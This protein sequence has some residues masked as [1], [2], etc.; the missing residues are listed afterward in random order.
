MNLY[1]KKYADGLEKSFQG[2]FSVNQK[3]TF[4][5]NISRRC[6]A[7]YVCLHLFGE[8][9][10]NRFNKIIELD[11]KFIN[12][13]YDVY[14]CEID[15]SE[16]GVG[17]FYYKYEI[18]SDCSRFYGVDSSYSALKEISPY[19][20]GSIQ[21]L[22]YEESENEPDWIYGGIMYHIF[23]DRFCKSGKCVP[24]KE[25]IMNDDWYDG[26]PQYANV[27]GGYVENNM[28]FGG[29][30]YGIINKLDYISSLGVNCLYLSPIFEAHSNHKYDTAD[31]MTVDSMFGSEK[32]LDE[33]IKECNKRNIHIILD[34][35]FNHT[36]SDSIYFNKNGT[37]NSIGAYQSKNSKFYEWYNFKNYPNDYEC[38]WNVKILPRV[39]SDTESY[40]QF[41][42]GDNGVIEKWMKKGISG[43]RLDVAD[44]L[45][46]DFLKMLNKKLKGI[47]PKGI[48]YGEVWEDASNKIAYDKRKKYFLGNELDSVMNY[49][50]REAIIEYIKNG[51][52]DLFFSTCNM[53]Y[54]HYP[55][56]NANALM[57]VLGTHDTERILTV[58]NGESSEGYTNAELSTKKMSEKEKVLAVN[59]LKQAYLVLATV[60]GVPCIYYGDEAGMEGYRDPFNRRPYP[61][62]KETKE[63]VEYYQAIGNIR[64]NESL[65]KQ[66]NFEI[67]SCDNELLAFARYDKNAFVVTIINRSKNKYNIDSIY[68]FRNLESNRKISSIFPNKSYILKCN[69]KFIKSNIKFTK[70][71]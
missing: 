13:K 49:P 70:K 52:S 44:E 34:G 54:S 29:D 48:I 1:E 53:L 69:E 30:L 22:I 28:F 42:L 51:N 59:M 18:H 8:G 24:K 16:I 6:G 36:G 20:D 45:S 7:D 71:A 55:K 10:D 21:L 25:A 9:I 31:Y 68:N 32:A 5:L 39:K 62:G 33:L 27:P 17:L 26:I 65:Y 12:G 38:W 14:E 58:L 41:I 4:Q 46:D 40:K 11:W 3:V 19:G 50:L 2:Y 23:V 63:L 37:Y 47:N 67:I 56:K 60:P 66:G 35:V 61:W 15:L 64:R 43:F 57:N